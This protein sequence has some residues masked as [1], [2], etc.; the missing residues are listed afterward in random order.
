MAKRKRVSKS[1]PDLGRYRS[2][3]ELD[4]GKL[5][6]RSKVAYEYETVKI[7]WVSTGF[8][9]PDFLL[10]KNGIVVE[11]K[12]RFLTQD[13]RKHTHVM[14]QHPDIDIRF[15]F[16]N[17]DYTLSKV[18]K[19]TYAQWCDRKGIKWA[20][21]YIPKSWWR[22]KPNQASLQALERLKT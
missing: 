10:L 14:E 17:P 4:N 11:T 9:N 5:L 3:L 2:S 1:K 13:R 6:D 19:T 15:V 12:G 18:S 22:E 7:P 21:K 16:W 20:D 8:Y